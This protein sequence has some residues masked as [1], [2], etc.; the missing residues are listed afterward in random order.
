M[1]LLSIESTKSTP[2]IRIW[3]PR[4]TFHSIL[5]KERITMR[6]PLQSSFQA[7]SISAI[8]T[9]RAG[10]LALAKHTLKRSDEIH[11]SCYVEDLKK[12]PAWEYKIQTVG[13]I[14]EDLKKRPHPSAQTWQLARRIYH[15]SASLPV[16]LALPSTSIP[17]AQTWRFA[18]DTAVDWHDVFKCYHQLASAT[19]GSHSTSIIIHHHC[20]RRWRRTSAMTL[21]VIS[22][23]YF[24]LHQTQHDNPP[25]PST[26]PTTATS[27]SSSTNHCYIM[28]TI[29]RY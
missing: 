28:P 1:N 12:R 14:V 16:A 4:S 6:P 26:P 25:T 8:I 10:A 3:R 29:L 7:P 22:D 5:Q 15:C 23:E 2:R 24:L 19:L 9:A 17:P 21:V 13:T 20:R 18:E 11:D 27:S